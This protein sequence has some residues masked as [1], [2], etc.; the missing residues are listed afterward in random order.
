M[1]SLESNYDLIIV[2]SG[3]GSMCAALAAKRLGKRAVI[4][5]KRD[6]IGGS[7]GF[8]GGVWWVP[9]NPLMARQGIADSVEKAKTYFDSVVT[10]K[11]PAVTQERRDAFL[12]ASRRMVSFLEKEGMKFRRPRTWPDYYDDLPGGVSEGRSLMAVNFNIRRLGR[13]ADR[14]STYAPMRAIPVGADLFPTLFTMK[15]TMAGKVAAFRVAVALMAK[16]LFPWREIVANG[17]AVQG[18]MLEIALREQLPIFPDTAVADFIVENDRVVGVLIEQKGQRARVLANDGVL[19]NAGGFS[20]NQAMRNQYQQRGESNTEW[21]NANSG[22]T[23]E[24]L[25]SMI[26]LG[27]ATDCMDTAWWVPTSRGLDGSWPKGQVSADGSIYPSMHHLDLSMPH[28]M[29]VDQDGRRLADE[30]GAYMEIGERMYDRQRK[31]GRAIPCWTIFEKRNRERYPWGAFPPGVTPQEWIDSGYMKKADTIEA[32][33]ELCG[34]DKAGLLAEVE[35]FNGYCRA[36]VDLEFNRG[37]RCFDRAHGDPTNRPNANLG[38]IEEGPFYAVA[39]FPG[40]VGTAGGVVTDE[41][42]RVLRPDGSAIAGLY[43]TG[44]STA[45]VFGRVYPGAGASI[46]AS[47]TFA[48]IAAHHSAGADHQL[49]KLIG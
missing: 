10:Y 11:G 35:K 5:E 14:L 16:K 21:T 25:E 1:S 9:N 32:L 23:G 30:S 39:M 28:L 19:V 42:A 24:V 38:A 22:D 8:S 36:G 31:T 43:A 4:L 47:F 15:R 44:N 34:I 40:D 46:A 26:K 18:R 20:R 27:A 17:A 12:N 6:K 48:L 29:M 2:G 45:S 49:A 3:G 13:W 7:T 33:A 41:F 37:G